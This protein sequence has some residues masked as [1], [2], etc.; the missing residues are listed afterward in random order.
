MEMAKP[1]KRR[2][3]TGVV[4]PT[5]KR[6]GGLNNGLTQIAPAAVARIEQER[7]SLAPITERNK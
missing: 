1:R 7:S 6:L 4:S 5:G 2:M 3:M